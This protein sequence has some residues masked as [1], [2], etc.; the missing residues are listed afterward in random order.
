MILAHNVRG[1]GMLMAGIAFQQQQLWTIF[2]D[3][4]FCKNKH[5]SFCSS[6]AKIH[7]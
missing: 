5:E 1:G 7:S 3:A 4:D 6:L 2:A